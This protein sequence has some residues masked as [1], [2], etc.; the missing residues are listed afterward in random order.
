MII[1]L[2]RLRYTPSIHPSILIQRALLAPSW[3]I[4]PCTNVPYPLYRYSLCVTFPVRRGGS[5]PFQVD[6]PASPPSH[7]ATGNT[8]ADNPGLALTVPTRNNQTQADDATSSS[9]LV[10]SRP[11]PPPKHNKKDKNVILYDKKT[12]MRRSLLLHSTIAVILCRRHPPCWLKES[13][14]GLHTCC[15]LI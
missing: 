11:P 13:G 9:A 4:H 7:P 14:H 6:L 12:A 3:P 15:Y 10:Y 8:S 2:R 1:Q 5:N